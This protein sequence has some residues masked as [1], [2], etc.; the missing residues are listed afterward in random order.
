MKHSISLCMI[1]KNEE[2]FLEKCLSSINNQVD[3]III[4]DTGSTD[5]TKEIANSF[6]AQ[7]YDL[8]WREDF[9]IA[10]NFSISKATSDYIL[11]LDA[12]EYLDETSD[13]QEVLKTKRDHYTVKIKNNLSSGSA[14]FHP[15][16]RLFKNFLGLNYFGKIHEHLNVYDPSLNLSHEYTTFT[17]N[18]DGYKNEVVKDKNKH[19][20]NIIML[21]EEVE[22]NPS[23]YNYYNLGTQYRSNNQFD[24]AV[25]AYRIAFP[26]SKNQLYI[27]SL[28]YNMIDCLRELE[29]YEE[30]LNVVDGAIESFPN[31]TDFHF[32]KG[33]IFEE[34]EYYQ[35]AVLA[36]QHC[37][38]LGEVK[39]LQTFE[40]V[41]SFLSYIRLGNI[42]MKLGKNLLAFDMAMEALM[43]NKSNLT[44]LRMYLEIVQK[45]KIPA[46]Q[47]K[48]H[49]SKIYPIQNSD[50]LKN[51]VIVL[52]IIKSPLLKDYI[53]M[54]NLKVESAVMAV[55]ELYA[56]NYQKAYNLWSNLDVQ[57]EKN[58]VKDIILISFLLNQNQLLNKYKNI[59]NLNDK[60]WKILN[61]V[62]NEQEIKVSNLSKEF[63]EIILFI[64]ER[65]IYLSEDK[66]IKYMT[67]I[68]LSSKNSV[69]ELAERL[70]DNGLSYL[71]Q[72][73][74]VN[75]Y[76][77]NQKDPILV[78]RL[79]DT[80]VKQRQF[81]EALSFYNHAISLKSHY[82]VF[83]KAFHVYQELDDQ[84]GMNLVKR[85]I[86]RNYPLV[87]W[88]K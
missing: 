57:I 73:I 72:T 41:G 50:D 51:L 31:Y 48:I 53:N 24:K 10:R 19:Q 39:L 62:V 49:L 27:Q 79:A 55:S 69:L 56:K 63:E 6:H 1:V 5:R 8:E 30:A 88:V 60:E 75:E 14:I 76:K 43:C 83:E 22:K 52:T 46:E 3:E 23:G 66:K 84:D 32:M 35:D 70:N 65:L 7:V 78:E 18:H 87:K 36:Y 58:D 12:D 13:L 16:V 67:D 42:Y 85:E 17:I 34:L 26:L 82:P 45:T 25:D 2:R 80:C 40:G 38:K 21:L 20:R 9:S 74:L 4:V 29:R 59:I 37:L 11:V 64:V 28:L 33:R 68:F 44:A 15:A 61:K 54:Y 86:E 47:V 81:K 71:A 77:Q